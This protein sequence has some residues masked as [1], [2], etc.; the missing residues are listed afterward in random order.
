M[1]LI[2]GAYL[3]EKDPRLVLRNYLLSSDVVGAGNSTDREVIF[4]CTTAWNRWRRGEDVVILRYVPTYKM[5][6]AA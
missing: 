3:G 2:S 4:K 1:M 6:V 5:P